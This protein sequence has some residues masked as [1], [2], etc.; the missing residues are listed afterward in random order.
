MFIGSQESDVRE[1]EGMKERENEKRKREENV[2]KSQ[3]TY[4]EMSVCLS[5]ENY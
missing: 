1:K 2:G 5:V 3:T 4:Q